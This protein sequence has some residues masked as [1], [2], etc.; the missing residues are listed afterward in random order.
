MIHVPNSQPAPVFSFVRRNDRDKIVAVLNFSAEPCTAT[1]AE[2]LYPGTYS[3]YFSRE[4]VS[5]DCATRLTVAPWGYPV[6]VR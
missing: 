3:D 4:T 1:F 2:H 6:F 5:L